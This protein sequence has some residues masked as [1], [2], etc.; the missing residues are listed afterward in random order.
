M[1]LFKAALD[2]L[3]SKMPLASGQGRAWLQVKCVGG[4]RAPTT[5]E[6]NMADCASAFPLRQ[7]PKL[8]AQYMQMTCRAHEHMIY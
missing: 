2:E 1:P 3:A 6:E 7:F 4:W 5:G 8:A